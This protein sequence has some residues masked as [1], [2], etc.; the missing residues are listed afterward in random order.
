MTRDGAARGE[1]VPEESI[2]GLAELWRG[3]PARSRRAARR[4]PT[5]LNPL[6]L[7]ARPRSLQKRGDDAVPP[8]IRPMESPESKFRGPV[9][10]HGS[11]PGVWSAPSSDS[12]PSDFARTASPARRV[13]VALWPP[14]AS[15]RQW[16][17]SAAT[18]ANHHRR[19]RFVRNPADTALRCPPVRARRLQ[20]KEGSKQDEGFR[21][22]D[23]R[24]RGVFRKA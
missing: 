19:S 10:I 7:V 24:R 18:R 2:F 9:L 23:T 20:T 17:N 12:L 14:A 15:F 5:H 11:A 6:N 8:A 13:P 16:M 3:C 22:L 21:R 4:A 1:P